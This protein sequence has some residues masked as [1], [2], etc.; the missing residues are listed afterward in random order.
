MVFLVLIGVA[1][2]LPVH[3]MSEEGIAIM[4]LTV[5]ELLHAE[6]KIAEG[7]F[8]LAEATGIAQPIV[9]FVSLKRSTSH[10]IS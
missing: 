3:V 4:T 8:H 7:I 1:A 9:A 2:R 5:L 6:A 10:N